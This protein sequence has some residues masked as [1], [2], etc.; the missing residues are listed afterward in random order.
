MSSNLVGP[1]I[2]VIGNGVLQNSSDVF[3]ILDPDAG[4]SRTFRV[5]LNASGSDLNP[6]DF[7]AAYT[8]LE[9]A[10]YTALSTYTTTELK[11]YVDQ[12][13]IL[14]NRTPV[15]SI[16]AFPNSLQ[17]ASGNPW[18]FIA[19]LGLQIVRSSSPV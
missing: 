18:A 19:S 13:A 4:G 9:P 5:P 6:V 15:G 1:F 10:T 16:T 12:L 2:L 11:A 8:K 3:N 7:W 14:R 17:M